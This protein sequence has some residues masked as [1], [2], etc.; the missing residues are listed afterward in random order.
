MAFLSYFIYAFHDDFLNAVGIIWEKGIQNSIDS[1]ESR[2]S[3]RGFNQTLANSTCYDSI[4]RYLQTRSKI[5]SISLG[6]FSL[7]FII[8]TFASIYFAYKSRHA[9]IDEPNIMSLSSKELN[10]IK[11][12]LNLDSPVD[13]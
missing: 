10:D 6:L 11:E 13:I 5:Y 3:C 12:P 7:I 1:I 4:N 9:D 2:F 8:L